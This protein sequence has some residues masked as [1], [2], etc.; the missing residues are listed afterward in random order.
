MEIQVTV[1]RCGVERLEV[2][3]EQID[4]LAFVV[5]EDTDTAVVEP[6]GA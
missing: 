4:L 1:G 6:V 3:A 5:I 2:D